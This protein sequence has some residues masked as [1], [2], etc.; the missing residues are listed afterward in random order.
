MKRTQLLAFVLFAMTAMVYLSCD[1]NAD[2]AASP[3]AGGAGGSLA[4]F[5]IAGNYLYIVSTRTLEVFDIS[6]PEMPA[7]KK[8]VNAG[9]DIETIFPYKDKLF[10][11]ART[12]MY[13]FSLADPLNPVKEGS[14][15]HFRACDPV[16]SNDSLSYVTLRSFGTD[17]GNLKNVLNVYNV[18]NIKDPKLINTIEMKSPYGLGIKD[19]GLYVCEGENGLAVMDL[20]NPYSPVKKMDFR[21]EVYYDV[22]PYG[23]VLITYIRN[24]VCFYD[25]SNP[26]QPVLLSKLKG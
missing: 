14:I 13:I 2:A 18:K 9:I 21:D 4:R 10:L 5:A 19:K 7:L 12:G 16:V 15:T 23:N 8:A 22:I 6:N 24:G 17:C 25:I 1:K 20:D 26:L 11:G 3:T